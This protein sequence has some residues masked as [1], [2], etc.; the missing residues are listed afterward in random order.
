MKKRKTGIF[1]AVMLAAGL[2][3]NGCGSA[4]PFDA[5]GYVKSVLD[6][7]YQGEYEE[8]ADF[9]DI[10]VDDAKAEIE[11][12]RQEQVDAEFTD[13]DGITE[14]GKEAYANS[15]TELDKLMHY[16]VGE[17]K[18]NDDGSFTVPVTIEPTNVYQTVEQHSSDVTTEML[19]QGTDPSTPEGFAQVLNESMKRAMDGI[20]YSDPETIE[21]TVAQDS[22]G[23]YG[24]SD[25]DMQKIAETM[26]PQ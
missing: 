9:R 22:D 8:Y 18:E 7:N 26:M 6:A 25:A 17:A 12:S 4:E 19:E 2:F 21:I 24:I 10:S 11:K 5:S 13:F 16:E 15:L 14:E 1:M 23:A 20:E 3:L